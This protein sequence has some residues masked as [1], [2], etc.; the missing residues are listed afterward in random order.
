METVRKK[1]NYGD[2]VPVARGSIRYRNYSYAEIAQSK[3]AGLKPG[4]ITRCNLVENEI[5]SRE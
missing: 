2:R 4:I 3:P 5:E 1:R